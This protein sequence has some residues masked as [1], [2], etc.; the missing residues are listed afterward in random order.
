MLNN[1]HHLS[2]IPVASFQQSCVHY[3]PE[4]FVELGPRLY[5]FD[6]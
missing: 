3:C 2:I 4:E 1:I 5:Y 6:V